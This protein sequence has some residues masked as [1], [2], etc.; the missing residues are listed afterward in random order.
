M[1]TENTTVDK[2]RPFSTMT[3]L[4]RGKTFS[5]ERPRKTRRARRENLSST[6]AQGR[7][8]DTTTREI[9]FFSLSLL[10][11]SSHRFERTLGLG[12][13]PEKRGPGEEQQNGRTQARKPSELVGLADHWI[14]FG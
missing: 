4:R 8:D 10:L 6:T 13:R 3:S 12:T 7:H 11:P 5:P 2:R 1:T 14:G 9:F